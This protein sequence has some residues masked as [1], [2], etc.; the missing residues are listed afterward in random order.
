MESAT[1]EGHGGMLDRVDSLSF[2][3]PISF[4]LTRYYFT[5]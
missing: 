3:A 2:A 1:A 4:H 5:A